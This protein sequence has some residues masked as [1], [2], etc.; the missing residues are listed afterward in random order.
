MNRC[1]PAYYDTVGKY[2]ATTGATIKASFISGLQTPYG[3][4]ISGTDLYVANEA[5]ETLIKTG[6]RETLIKTG[7]RGPGLI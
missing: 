3:L 2:D 7:V 5:R 4:A 6:V 1:Y